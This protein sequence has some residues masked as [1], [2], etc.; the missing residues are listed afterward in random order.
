MCNELI[1]HLNTSGLNKDTI[2][3]LKQLI[4]ILDEADKLIIVQVIDEAKYV[5]ITGDAG[6]R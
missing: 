1:D 3:L 2:V 5:H 6:W 4:A